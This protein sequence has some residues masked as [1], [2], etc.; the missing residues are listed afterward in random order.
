MCN[1]DLP[2]YDNVVTVL[3]GPSLLAVLGH[4]SVRLHLLPVVTSS[5]LSRST[6]RSCCKGELYVESVAITSR[7]QPCDIPFPSG[8]FKKVIC[9]SLRNAFNV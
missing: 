6:F 2:A 4:G 7:T 9:G 5:S 3:L 1:S 8:P